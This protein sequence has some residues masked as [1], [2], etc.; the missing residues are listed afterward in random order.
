M[1][2]LFP[3]WPENLPDPTLFLGIH[4]SHQSTARYGAAELQPLRSTWLVLM[5]FKPSPFSLFSLVPVAV[6]YFP[7][8]LQLLLGRGAC[9]LFSPH[10]PSPSSLHTQKWFPS[11]CGFS[12]PKFSSSCHVPAE[13]CGS[14]CA[15]C[16]VNP[17]I[18]FLGVQDDLVLIW[19][20]VVA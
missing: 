18:G 14:G 9:P 10:A 16:C 8:S 12:L 20:S 17:Q 4:L 3:V 11:L 7:L 6:S 19:L 5:E 1:G 15:D 2:R 13:F